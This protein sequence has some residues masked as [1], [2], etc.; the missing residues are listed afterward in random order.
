MY[1]RR[2]AFTLIELLVVIAIIAV[3]IALLL[4]AVQAAREAARRS[5]C[6]NNMKQL[7]LA[8][9][10]HHDSLGR[11]PYG[12]FEPYAVANK[13]ISIDATNP[14][15]PN[16]LIYL[17]PYVEQTNLYNSCNVAG[18]PGPNAVIVKDGKTTPT[19]VNLD[20]R[21]TTVRQTVIS[22]FL[23]PS[24]KGGTQL[25]SDPA[26]LAPP[27]QGWARGNYAANDGPTDADHTVGDNWQESHYKNTYYG[28]DNAHWADG[29]KIGVMG[30]NYGYK[31]ADITDG[32]SSTILINE[33]RVGVTAADHRGT[34]ALG[35][36]GASLTGA[37]RDYNPG[38]NNRMDQADE[39]QGCSAFWYPGIGS[40][41]GMGCINDPGAINAGANARSLHPGGVNSA[42]CDGS[43]RFIKNTV[44]VQIWFALQASK[45]GRILSADSY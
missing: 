8:C 19:N 28:G 31:F 14:F 36:M 23:C 3:L 9:H 2:K 41:D 21:S 35:L 16:W 11:L 32:L 22:S 40:K 38:P 24:D 33:V 4:P 12:V 13:D 1:H 10:N 17:L 15:G 29:P 39:F 6:V 44:D 5:Q 34:W 30:I 43:V 42:F 25:Y 27:E 18:Y 20:W 37:A 26:K 7:A 45:E